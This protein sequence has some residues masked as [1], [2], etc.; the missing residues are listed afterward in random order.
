[1]PGFLLNGKP[2]EEREGATVALLLESLNLSRESVI[3]EFNEEFLE[4]EQ[5]EATVLGQGDQVEIVR[6]FAGG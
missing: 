6:A 3:V 4:K 5:F 2:H 1:M